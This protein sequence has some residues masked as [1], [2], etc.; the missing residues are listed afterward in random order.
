MEEMPEGR[1]PYGAPL[2]V[3]KPSPEAKRA[4]PLTIRFLLWALFAP[5]LCI[6][7]LLLVSPSPASLTVY[8]LLFLFIPPFLILW[9]EFRARG[10]GAVST[11]RFLVVSAAA[12]IAV[13]AV[14]ALYGVLAVIAYSIWQHFSYG[15]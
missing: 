12:A 3:V 15:T 8:L 4:W 9:P 5:L 10:F 7:A 6:A 1:N 2:A 13:L 14:A 11:S